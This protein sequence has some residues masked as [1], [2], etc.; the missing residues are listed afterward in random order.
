MAEL[1]GD[2]DLAQES[3]RADQGAEL[4]VEDLDGDAAAV[5]Q[6][7]GEEHGGHATA[8]QLALEPVAAGERYAQLTGEI[9]HGPDPP[10]PCRPG[11]L[12]HR[13]G[14]AGCLPAEPRWSG[15]GSVAMGDG[16]GGGDAPAS[17]QGGR[18]RADFAPTLRETK[19]IDPRP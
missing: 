15:A 6:V 7:L 14:V 17:S 2:L 5:L 18:P 16:E 3:L 10:R 12:S 19:E 1:R 4:G 13:R 8:A 11:R 9:C